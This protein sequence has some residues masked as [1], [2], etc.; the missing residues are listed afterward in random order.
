MELV[1]LHGPVSNRTGRRRQGHQRLLFTVSDPLRFDEYD[2]GVQWRENRPLRD[3]RRPRC[4]RHPL[5]DSGST[6]NR[7]SPGIRQ[8]SAPVRHV[9]GIRRGARLPPD[10]AGRRSESLP[11]VTLRSAHVSVADRRFAAPREHR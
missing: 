9:G 2:L 7:F 8:C 3:P 11:A 1:F 4:H 10:T 5:D 6:A